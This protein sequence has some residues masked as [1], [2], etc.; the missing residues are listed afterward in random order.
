MIQ[1]FCGN[2]SSNW[3]HDGTCRILAELNCR[4]VWGSLGQ[5]TSEEWGRSERSEESACLVRTRAVDAWSPLLHEI[6]G[7][8]DLRKYSL[9]KVL[10]MKHIMPRCPK[11]GVGR[12]HAIQP[13]HVSSTARAAVLP[14]DKRHSWNT[15]IAIWA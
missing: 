5:R 7:R 9:H 4:R 12:T 8:L 10:N 2:R 14:E 6:S 1:G 3:E 15:S 11:W 13:N